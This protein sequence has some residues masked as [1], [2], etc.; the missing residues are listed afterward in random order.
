MN[1]MN[2]L[3]CASEY[4]PYGSGIANVA[5]NVVEQLKKMGVDCTL[6][7]PTGPDI[8]LGSR[9]LIQKFGRLGLLYYWYQV[10]KHLET[11]KDYELIW[12]HQPLF[13]RG[14][15]LSKSL[16]TMHITSFGVF[17]QIQQ[18]NYPLFRKIYKNIAMHLEKFCLS[19]LDLR[20]T[21]FSAVS[22]QVCNELKALRITDENISYI[23]NG[24][25]TKLFKPVEK[26]E[27]EKLREEFGIPKDKL[28]LLSTGNLTMAK[29]P[30][31]LIGIYSLI[32]NERKDISLVIAGSG[33]LEKRI[34]EL[35]EE[36]G[37]NAIFLGH[38]NYEKMHDLYACADVYIMTS[39][40]EGLPLTLLEAMSSGLPCVVS[41]VTSI[42][43]IVSD[44]KAGIVVDFN[45]ESKAAHQI[46]DFLNGGLFEYG[47]NAR[48]YAIKNL[49]WGEIAKKYLR[50]FQKIIDMK[51]VVM[52]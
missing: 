14:S 39:I 17:K 18:S 37:I 7:S 43:S 34:R 12:L 36:K 31:K 44:A 1:E 8:K 46:I 6:C 24:V 5:Y 49:D 32:E 10:R 40:Y 48:E 52:I 41:A 21:N 30:L 19:R 27:K 20:N 28:M 25:D 38:V 4:Y 15:L 23:P 9:L 3:V 50:E 42:S 26:E 11:N 47:K 16:I 33:E 22:L 29:N 2:L 35:S 45:N 13:I 51:G